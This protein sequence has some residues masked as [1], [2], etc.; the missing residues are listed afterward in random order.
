MPVPLLK[1]PELTPQ[2]LTATRRNAR[3]ST[4]PRSPAAKQNIKLNAL[5]HGLYVSD[6]NLPQSMLES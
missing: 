2:L 1:S 3:H 6:E 4:G 5:K